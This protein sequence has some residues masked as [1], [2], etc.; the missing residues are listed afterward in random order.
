MTS[1]DSLG[2][3]L[4]EI[5][6]HLLN[7]FLVKLY[8]TLQQNS[9]HAEAVFEPLSRVVSSPTLLAV[10]PPLSSFTLAREPQLIG[11]PGDG[12][13]ACWGQRWP[14]R[15]RRRWP[16]GDSGRSGD[17]RPQRR[18]AAGGHGVELAVGRRGRSGRRERIEAGAALAVGGVRN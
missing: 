2:V 11:A 1:A 4:V 18:S 15:W 12:R 17:G 9:S 13:R 14:A 3:C 16:M 6:E 5:L 8:Q 7:L 10:P